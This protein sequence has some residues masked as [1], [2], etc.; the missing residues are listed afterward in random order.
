[1]G[2]VLANLL[3]AVNGATTLAGSSRTLSSPEDRARFHRLRSKVSAIA[4]GGQTFRSEPYQS[5]PVDLF[6][7]SRNLSSKDARKANQFFSRLPPDQ[8]IDVIQRE[9]SGDVLVE[10]GVAFL[11]PLIEK[12]LISEFYITR[13][14]LTGDGDFFDERALQ[15]NYQK[16][17]EEKFPAEI[18]QIWSPQINQLK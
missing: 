11:L 2:I 13:S 14:M 9:R 3:V 17:S 6:I 16:V 10:G 8:L 1:M 5:T 12:A 7:S 4:I 18:F 15:R